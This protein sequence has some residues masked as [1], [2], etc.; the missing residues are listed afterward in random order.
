VK[1]FDVDLCNELTADLG[2]CFPF[3]DV[4]GLE[5][6]LL[7]GLTSSSS[8]FA[9]RFFEGFG[10]LSSPSIPLACVDLLP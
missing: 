3:D 2:M 4:S 1:T 10:W 6:A 7:R 9:L 8:T 5:A